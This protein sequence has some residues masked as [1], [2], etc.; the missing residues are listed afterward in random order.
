LKDHIEDKTKR[1]EERK[2]FYEKEKRNTK[3]EDPR[4]KSEGEAGQGRATL[5]QE[6]RKSAVK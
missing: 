6:K 4:R 1:E 2:G 3:G 5:S